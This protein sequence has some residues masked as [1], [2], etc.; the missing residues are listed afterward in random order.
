MS[1]HHQCSRTAG[2][3]RTETHPSAS[4]AQKEVEHG[5]VPQPP[6]QALTQEGKGIQALARPASSGIWTQR[7]R[8]LLVYWSKCGNW[9]IMP[10]LLVMFIIASPSVL[11]D[12]LPLLMFSLLPPQFVLPS[13]IFTSC[14]QHVSVNSP[15]ACVTYLCLTFTSFL[16]PLL[17]GLG[18]LYT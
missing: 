6:C 1:H 13:C 5:R 12:H 14:Y 11:K 15:Y 16:I 8:L 17:V 18:S 4:R 2:V 7:A 10:H 3:K 9:P